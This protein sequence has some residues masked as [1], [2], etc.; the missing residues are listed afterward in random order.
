MGK[1]VN[2]PQQEKGRT[3]NRH[4]IM[5]KFP[6]NRNEK[7]IKACYKGKYNEV[8][9]LVNNGADVNYVDN[10]GDTPFLIAAIGANVDMCRYLLDKGANINKINS[11]GMTAMHLACMGG[12]GQEDVVKLLY[13]RGANH[14]IKDLRDMTPLDYAKTKRTPLEPHEDN[15]SSIV[16]VLEGQ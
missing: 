1:K 15:R 14:N 5:G 9:R 7:L 6:L 10:G 12:K 4:I 2:R 3:Q 11:L 8:V 16:A 13:Q